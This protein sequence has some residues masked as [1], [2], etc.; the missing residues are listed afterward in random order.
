[1]RLTLILVFFAVQI[2]FFG[3]DY[4]VI[5]EERAGGAVDATLLL[6]TGT[7]TEEAARRCYERYSSEL[8]YKPSLLSVKLFANE[9]DTR[10]AQSAVAECESPGECRY[11]LRTA[12]QPSGP[13]AEVLQ[14]PS[15]VVLR[16]RI[17]EASVRKTVLEGSDPSKLGLRWIEL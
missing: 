5:R 3:A 14:S 2:Q 9:S 15:G 10:L 7:L 11:M 17:F 1:M 16:Y 4:E 6:Q 13:I 12:K 8:P